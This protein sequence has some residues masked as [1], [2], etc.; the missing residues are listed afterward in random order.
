MTSILPT[1][2]SEVP[3]IAIAH[4]ADGV[5]TINASLG[6]VFDVAQTANITS[7]TINNGTDGATII[8]RLKQDSTGGRTIALGA[9]IA[10]PA[11]VSFSPTTT[12]NELNVFSLQKRTAL[13][14]WLY[15]P[16]FSFA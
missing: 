5:L 12:G 7:I 16:S 1:P 11:G 9:G 4:S 14:K 10:L 8:L 2:I 6:R 3:P 15:S 13:S